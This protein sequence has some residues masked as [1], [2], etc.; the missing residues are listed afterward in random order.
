[1]C[2]Q[3]LLMYKVSVIITLNYYAENEKGMGGGNVHL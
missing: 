3:I 1:M 2:V